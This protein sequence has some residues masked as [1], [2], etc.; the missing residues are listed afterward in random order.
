MEK[1]VKNKRERKWFNK[2]RKSKCRSRYMNI[3]KVKK[4]LNYTKLHKNI[5]ITQEQYDELVELSQKNAHLCQSSTIK[6]I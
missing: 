6:D 2:N 3:R 5:F 1:R 4:K